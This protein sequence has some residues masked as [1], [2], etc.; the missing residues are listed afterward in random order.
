MTEIISVICDLFKDVRMKSRW[1]LLPC[2]LK[3]E[4][5]VFIGENPNQNPIF[6]TV[7]PYNVVPT[8]RCKMFKD[9]TAA[10]LVLDR[11]TLS[12]TFFIAFG[13]LIG[14][15]FMFNVEDNVSLIGAACSVLYYIN[16]T[17]MIFIPG[18]GY[19]VYNKG[20][21]LHTLVLPDTAPYNHAFITD[22]TLFIFA[23]NIADANQAIV[24]Q[25]ASQIELF[26]ARKFRLFDNNRTSNYSGHMITPIKAVIDQSKK[27][28]TLTVWR[29]T[30]KMETVQLDISAVF[31]PIP[32]QKT[33]KF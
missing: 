11:F 23:L 18:T 25:L 22:N 27:Y 20:D 21:A 17:N 19:D 5:L 14:D 8:M 9:K 15:I 30:K 1:K 6:R 33:I 24:I 7:V 26:V 13:P 29:G 10:L 28:L 12:V 16:K 4:L 3:H 32:K 31:A 2:T